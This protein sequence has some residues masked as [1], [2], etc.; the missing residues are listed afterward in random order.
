ME[1]DAHPIP[2]H[3]L[4]SPSIPRLCVRVGT[5]LVAALVAL[6]FATR[7]LIA[8]GFR[9]TGRV[10][11]LAGTDS[12]PVP[13]VWAV[14]HRVALAGGAAIDSARTD[15]TG[16]YWVRGP[17]R[18]TGSVY[19]VSATYAGIAYF[20]RPVHLA[21][22]D[23]LDTA[24]TLAVYDT[25]SG[26]PAITLAQRHLIV[27]RPE[28]DG[29]RHVL[30][31]LVL[32]NAGERTRIAPDTSRPVWEGGLPRGVIQ[33]EVGESD[34]SSEA[35]YRRRDS[36]AV[37]APVPPGEKQILVSYILPRSVP[38]LQLRVDQLVGRL[39]LL[40]EDSA[41]ALESGGLDRVESEVIEG[42]KFARFTKDK[43]LPGTRVSVRLAPAGFVAG[44]LWWIVVALSALALAAGL[45]VA[46]R[47]TRE[48]IRLAPASS[49]PE[50]LAAQI[51]ALDAA[52]EGR[53]DAR[54]QRQRALLKSRLEELLRRP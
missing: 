8:Q 38:R 37:A 33:F 27:R 45:L 5:W 18:D 15:R 39:N 2:L 11:H 47:R 54:Y 9:V 22:G 26:Q 32:R 12:T 21:R 10:I 46:W 20:T 17:M 24:E 13:G 50:L 14:F 42:V 16:R 48:T 34:V 25:S 53:T 49:D 41:A 43:V 7:S 51:A 19:I 1:D 30:E 4:P 6:G 28:R 29:S 35:I 44:S 23:A 40:V 3:R 31:L 52:F 36:M